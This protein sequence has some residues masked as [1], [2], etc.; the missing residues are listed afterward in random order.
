MISLSTKYERVLEV[1]GRLTLATSEQVNQC[2]YSQGCFRT[3]RGYLHYLYE[4]RLVDLM[5]LREHPKGNAKHVHKLTKRGYEMV[6]RMGIPHLIKPSDNRNQSTIQ[7]LHTTQSNWPLVYAWELTRS[8]PD[9]S[10]RLL[11]EPYLRHDHLKRHHAR[12]PRLPLIP[13]SFVHFL[14]PPTG[15]AAFCFELDNSTEHLKEDIKPKIVEYLKIAHDISVYQSIFDT[16]VMLVVW[17]CPTK[18]GVDRLL[19]A[20]EAILTEYNCTEYAPL[21]YF[22]VLEKMSGEEFYFSERF[23]QVG[24]NSVSLLPK[25]WQ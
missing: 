1:I 17:L 9:L 3:T 8:Y 21:F 18:K 12:S 11:S 23:K 14:H 16:D 24:G 15:E 13:D 6:A 7:L 2:L 10:V 4:N 22:A 25:E 19:K 5:Y 20:T